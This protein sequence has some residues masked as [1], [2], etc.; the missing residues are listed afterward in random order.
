[1]INYCEVKNVGVLG[2]TSLVGALLLPLLR[3]NSWH[4]TAYSRKDFSQHADGISWQQVK[5][6]SVQN[7]PEREAIIP[8]WVCL[9]P[10]WIL[11][12][13]FELFLQT[14][15]RR[16]VVLSSTSRFAK[17]HSSD[18][19]EQALSQRLE[20]GESMFREWA[21]IHG[22]EWVILRPT[23]IYGQGLDKNITEI[24]RLIRR[25]H[26]FPLFGNANGLRQPIHAEDVALG[27]IA[28]LY[29]SPA[30]NHAYNLSGQEILT[31]RELVSRIFDAL[32]YRQ[33]F[34]RIPFSIFRIA[35]ACLRL[36]P[37]YR[38]WSPAMAER[39]IQDLVFDHHDAERDLNFSPRAF[40]LSAV[41]VTG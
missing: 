23:L 30:A 19:A 1:M 2:A 37:R 35:V 14:K 26:F 10:I 3:K 41:D 17:S 6:N 38:K 39:M 13:F 16:V 33:R 8:C 18:L 12:N 21:E 32:G 11:P 36:L 5:D 29:A 40:V 27:C 20:K 22:I 34:I 9:T 31:Y 15:A 28:A 25:F 7:S 4:V 24:A